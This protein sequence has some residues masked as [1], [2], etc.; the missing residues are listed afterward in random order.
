MTTVERTTADEAV[1]EQTV[2]IATLRRCLRASAPEDVVAAVMDAVRDLGGEVLPPSASAVDSFPVDL[3][4]GDGDPLVPV[5]TGAASARLARVLPGLVEDARTAVARIRQE[6]HLEESATTDALTG[7]ANRRVAMRVLGR[8]DVGDTVVYID[9]DHFKR[10]NDT[11][12]HDAGDG[13]LRAFARSMR[14][15]ARAGD[16]VGRHGGE[17]FV[18]L[19]PRTGVDGALVVLDRLRWMW[20]AARPQPV[21]FSAGVATVASSGGRAALNRADAALYAAKRAGRDRVEV[22]DG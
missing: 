14:A 7:L 20:E 1:D 2:I 9:L 3:S 4:F 10:V 21:T 22:A 12:G 13:V 17:E 16:T 6:V 15:V 18:M 5:A 8:L 11:L 19:L